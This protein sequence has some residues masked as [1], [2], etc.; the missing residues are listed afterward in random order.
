V[1]DGK[2]PSFQ[3]S[4]SGSDE[5]MDVEQQLFSQKSNDIQSSKKASQDN[6]T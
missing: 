2:T 1:A 4:K 6:E 3:D 5:S